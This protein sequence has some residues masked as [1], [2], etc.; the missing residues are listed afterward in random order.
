M[1]CEIQR[2]QTDINNIKNQC[3]MLEAAVAKEEEWGGEALA[4]RD[5]HAKQEELEAA[6]QQ[7][8]QDVALQLCEYQELMNVKLALDIEITT[9]C[10]LLEGKESHLARDGV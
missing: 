5:A 3:A 4:L 2:L 9:Y 6:L 8:K 10:K 7:A 1:N